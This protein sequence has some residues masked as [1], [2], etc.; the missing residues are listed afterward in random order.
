MTR[1]R[2]LATGQLARLPSSSEADQAGRWL[3]GASRDRTRTT[4]GHQGEKVIVRTIKLMR[5]FPAHLSCCKRC[6]NREEALGMRV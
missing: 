3:M 6:T 2:T 1:L 5:R 4:K